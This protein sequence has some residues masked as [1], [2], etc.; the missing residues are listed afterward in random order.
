MQHSCRKYLAAHGTMLMLRSL[1]TFLDVLEEY[2][3]INVS[4]VEACLL[5]GL[6][7]GQILL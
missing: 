7:K 3:E 4:S 2:L 6:V 5:I 1:L